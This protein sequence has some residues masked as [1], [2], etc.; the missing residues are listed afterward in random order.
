MRRLVEAMCTMNK[1]DKHTMT[2]HPH[3]HHNG[4][5][6]LRQAIP[7]HWLA[8]LRAAFDAGVKPSAQW[9]VPRGWDWRHSMLDC[10]PTIQAVC[11]LPQVLA[12]VGELIGERFFLAQVEGREPVAGG[13]HQRLHRDLSAQRPG[14]TV[15]AMAFFDD[16]GPENGATRIVPG[17]HR[18]DPAAP[19]FDFTDESGAVQLS[20]TA[21][22]ILVFDVDLVHAGSLN[23]GG[24]RR[25]SILIGYASESL[26]DTYQQT[27]KL[28]NVRMDTA[29]RFE[30]ADFIFANV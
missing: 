18:P 28:R 21:G 30:P 11:R 23:I 1:K 6:L 20:G 17:S 2:D 15:G 4:Y 27:A 24:A 8:D 12:V 16:Y 7:A 13:G 5:A 14:D 26:Y 29:E 3:P 22:D 25:R 19:P 10:D 9:P